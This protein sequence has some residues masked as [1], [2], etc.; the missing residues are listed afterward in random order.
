MLVGAIYTLQ[1]CETIEELDAAKVWLRDYIDTCDELNGGTLR[2]LVQTF[3]QLKIDIVERWV[4]AFRMGKPHFNIISSSR[5]EGEFSWLWY[6]RLTSASTLCKSI[7]KIRWA[8]S[9]A[10]VR[11]AKLH[12][13]HAPTCFLL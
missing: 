9:R 10:P 12:A 13:S 1:R 7:M 6:L 4:R 2:N 5:I 3:F 11:I 8:A